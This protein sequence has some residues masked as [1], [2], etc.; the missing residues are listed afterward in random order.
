[1]TAQAEVPPAAIPE[2]KIVDGRF[3]P[4]R[5]VPFSESLDALIA[6]I[7]AGNAPNLGHFC[8][9]CCTPL[10]DA[11]SA[12]PTCGAS[13]L[14]TPPRAK[15]SQPLAEIYTAKRKK[16]ARYVHSAAWLG[17]LLGAGISMA[18]IVVLPSWTKFL[19]IAFLI[20]GSYYLASYLGNVLVQDYAYRNG[21][22]LFAQRWHDYVLT[23]ERGAVDDD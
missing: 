9:Y 20:L 5:D 8:A 14:E 23:R 17:L 6:E 7:R 12:C 10:H 16:E 11:G 18:L 22:R 2:P 3:I 21:L 1:M 19:A 13:P 4:T 15:I